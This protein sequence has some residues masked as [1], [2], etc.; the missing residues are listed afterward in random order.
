M[1]EKKNNSEK[2]ISKREDIEELSSIYDVYSDDD[3]DSDEE[4][5]SHSENDTIDSIDSTKLSSSSNDSL[6]ENNENEKYEDETY[7]NKNINTINN[8]NND[9]ISSNND[10]N[11]DIDINTDTKSYNI[12]LD[13]KVS[14]EDNLNELE[15]LD[16]F[17][18]EVADKYAYSIVRDNNSI[19]DEME[20][21]EDKAIEEGFQDDEMYQ[22]K[23]KPFVDSKM[24]DKAKESL[25]KS[26]LHNAEAIEDLEERDVEERSFYAALFLS[27]KPVE[28][29][30]FLKMFTSIN[31]ENRLLTYV[32]KFNKLNLGMRIIHVSGGYQIV[33]DSEV[34][35]FLDSYFG[36]KAEVLSKASLETLSIIAYKQPITKAEIEDLRGVI[37]SGPMKYLLDRNLIRVIGRK[38]VPGRP[39]LYATTNGFLEY[40]GINSLSDLPTF[41][42][43]MELKNNQ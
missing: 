14:N 26:L 39:L 7:N 12:D 40:F 36:E 23:I 10:I 43:W 4:I 34:S 18:K 6:I 30:T 19:E 38:E 2:N 21:V 37:S 28:I 33:T 17:E 9:V 5:I 20:N 13:N 42:E 31:L 24:Y 25:Y 11:Q 16:D 15:E 1:D 35:S 27:G 32:E 8:F 22:D 3:F 41:R 29:K